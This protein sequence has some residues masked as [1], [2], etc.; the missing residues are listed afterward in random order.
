MKFNYFLI[1]LSFCLLS[2]CGDKTTNNGGG[3]V[4][5]DESEVAEDNTMTTEASEGA[6]P[7]KTEAYTDDTGIQAR[8][9][10][11]DTGFPKDQMVE[12]TPEMLSG[13][14][15][16]KYSCLEEIIYP[17]GWSED[18]KFAYLIEEA[19]E[20]VYNYT[21]H[22][23]IQ[24]TETDKQLVK[25]T[26]K[27][28]DQPSY[29]QDDTAIDLESVWSSRKDRYSE[30]LSQHN[31]R[32]GNGT[33]FYGMPWVKSQRPYRFNGINKMAHSDLFDLDFVS[34]HRLEASEQGG[35]KKII[36]KHT[37]GKYDLVIATQALGYFQSPFEDRVAV[38]DG[39][40]KRGY[41][42]P[43]NVLKLKVVGCDLSQWD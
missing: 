11:D 32:T 23:I 16:S 6:A 3:S 14:C 37:F 34:E 15:T 12:F 18:G 26:F 1:L 41:E 13:L 24:D 2:S 17:L 4:M 36:L 21:L 7:A 42:G 27:A 28:S 33:Q 30:L 22:F 25:E 35:S 19:N 9:A 40:E 10:I 31:I 43:P 39:F 8:S 38:V 29:K 5:V 20:A